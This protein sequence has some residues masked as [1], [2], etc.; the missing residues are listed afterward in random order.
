MQ[1][2]V[3]FFSAGQFVARGDW[4]HQRRTLDSSVLFLVE[5]GGFVMCEEDA[6]YAMGERD[7]LILRSGHTHFGEKSG[8]DRPPV[9]CWAHFAFV[10]SAP[11][12]LREGAQCIRVSQHTACK[13]Y[14]RLSILFHQLISESRVANAHPLSC[15]YL[16]SLLLIALSADGEWAPSSDALFARL[17]EYIRLNYRRSITLEELAAT[18]HYSA[19]YLSRLFRAKAGKPIKQRQ[20]ELRLSEAKELLLSTVKSI[21]EIAYESGYANEMFFIATFTRYEG[22]SPTQYRNTFGAFHQNDL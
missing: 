11:E 7:A 3:K 19:D 20:H 6:R 9:Y 18:F 5:S 8:S 12:A 4:V 14:D 17:Q 1:L 21:K 10:E 22:V 15:D 16:M 13:N 2:P